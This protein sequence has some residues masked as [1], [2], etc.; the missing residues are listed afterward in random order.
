MSTPEISVIIPVYNG[1]A[2]IEPAI[3]SVVAQT[4]QPLELIVVD[5]GSTD[6]SAER[7]AAIETPFPK[8]ILHQANKFQS[9]ARNLAAKHARGKFLAFLDHDDIW[10]PEHLEML[11]AP[12]VADERYGWSYCD[13][14]EIDA[15]GRLVAL[16]M[17]G[18]LDPGVQHPKTSIFNMLGADMYIFPSAAVVRRDAMLQVGGFDERL[19]GYEDDDLFL[20]LFRVGWLNAYLP[21]PLVRYRRHPASSAFSDR[22][23]ISRDIFAD[24]LLQNFP[25]DPVLVRFFVRDIIA[26]RFYEAGRSEYIRHFPHARWALCARAVQVMRRFQPMMDLPNGQRLLHWFEHRVMAHPRMLSAFYP[27]LRRLTSLPY[28]RWRS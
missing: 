13:I 14:D 16:N 26:P 24:K 1:G 27:V 28:Q 25:D 2:Y 5:D 6:G 3:A 10:Y 20:R 8:T 7:V 18:K 22:M 19:S 17:L 23:W 15:S 4:L 12:L 9:A 11:V 21:M